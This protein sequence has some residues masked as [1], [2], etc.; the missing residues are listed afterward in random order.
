MD[1]AISGAVPHVRNAADCAVIVL[2]LLKANVTM[3][4]TRPR[5][6]DPARLRAVNLRTAA[7]LFTI[8]LVFFA[9]IIVSHYLGG[10]AAGM[11]VRAIA[12]ALYLAVAI[13][14][15]VGSDK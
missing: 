5:S 11:S 14:G 7:I 9:G 10:V 3:V 8:A 15:N 6:A 12:I 4:P 1:V 2:A 13:G